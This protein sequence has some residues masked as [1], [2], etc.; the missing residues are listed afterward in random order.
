MRPCQFLQHRPPPFVPAFCRAASLGDA[1]LALARP[2]LSAQLDA[3]HGPA[4]M[5]WS[6]VHA[7][8]RQTAPGETERA[9][10]ERR[11]RSAVPGAISKI[12][13]VSC[14]RSST[15]SCGATSGAATSGISG[16]GQ[17]RERRAQHRQTIAAAL[18]GHWRASSKGD[19]H[20]NEYNEYGWIGDHRHRRDRGRTGAW[21]ADRCAFGSI[22]RNPSSRSRA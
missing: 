2:W 18:K 22:L 7:A 8:V 9:W 13:S 11:Q 3:A 14:G 5:A 12:W 19:D 17:R 16:G 4:T 21:I 1:S 20:D 6:P 15:L 10:R